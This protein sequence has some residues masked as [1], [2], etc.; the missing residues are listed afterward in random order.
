[1]ILSVTVVEQN[2]AHVDNSCQ[3]E[4]LVEGMQR[5]QANFII[6]HIQE[7]MAKHDSWTKTQRKESRYGNEVSEFVYLGSYELT[8]TPLFTV[9]ST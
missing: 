8:S 1:M 6:L 9:F 2:Q 5:S 7:P 3:K 4:T